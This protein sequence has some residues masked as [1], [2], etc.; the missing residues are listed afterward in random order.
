M[1]KPIFR[2]TYSIGKS[3]LTLDEIVDICDEGNMENVTI[4]ED[5]LT[6]FMKAFHLC[7]ERGKDLTYGLRI[8]LCNENLEDNSDHKAVIFAMDDT[9]CKL[10]NKIYSLAFVKNDGKLTYKELKSLWNKES[11]CFIVPFYDSFIHQNN[12]H[13]KNC[14]PELD[15]LNPIFWIEKNELPYDR[16]IEQKVLEFA[17]KNYKISF[18]KTICYRNK[19]DV[20]AL[21]T[22]KILCNRSF[23]RQ[24]TLSN[25][26]LS[27]FSSDEFCWESYK[28]LSK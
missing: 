10:L 27:H 6:S 7:K 22:Y 8:T 24:A 11:L 28:E 3:I 1:V 25:P 26:N 14:I 13:L 2:S 4:V 5:N 16:L 19:E 18:V 17:K 20:E 23:G 12:L 9:G 15:G 21:Q